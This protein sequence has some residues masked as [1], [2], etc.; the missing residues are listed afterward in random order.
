MG[1]VKRNSTSVY[2]HP[3]IKTQKHEWREAPVVLFQLKK[4]VTIKVLEKFRFWYKIEYQNK[5]G[6]LLGKDIRQMLVLPESVSTRN[7]E[8]Q[9]NKQMKETV[10]APLVTSKEKTV[11]FSMPSWSPDN[12]TIAIVKQHYHEVVGDGFPQH[13]DSAF[14]CLIDINTGTIS[15]IFKGNF[16]YPKW[17]P[18]G[19]KLLFSSSNR[20]YYLSV[21]TGEIIPM[22]TVESDEYGPYIGNP[23]WSNE[24]IVSYL[25]SYYESFGTLYQYSIK[26]QKI[27]EIG[28]NMQDYIIKNDGNKAFGFNNQFEY[29]EGISASVLEIKSRKNINIY[30]KDLPYLYKKPYWKGDTIKVFTIKNSF[31]YNKE[32]Y[33]Y[34]YW[35]NENG[36]I[37]NIDSIPC[38]QLKREYLSNSVWSNNGK[39]LID[40]MNSKL[41]LISSETLEM[42]EVFDANSHLSPE[43]IYSLNHW[44]YSWSADNEQIVICL[45]ENIYKIQI[46]D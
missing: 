37:L 25:I 19:T 40:K 6:W 18:D 42:E 36:Q 46:I 23:T 32:S 22:V 8:I 35:I 15:E 12:K 3:N 27:E 43:K 41:W 26:T 4:G 28:G 9:L 20:I 1:V 24:N 31:S 34:L 33:Q 17:S 16:S 10:V 44:A 30:H 21:N 39:Y 7:S 5:K 13:I 45:N 14:L 29:S 2:S 38:G 11:F